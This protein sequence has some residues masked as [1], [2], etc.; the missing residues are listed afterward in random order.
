MALAA[1]GCGGSSTKA[2][3]PVK[4][5][6]F[7]TGWTLGG[8]PVRGGTAIV[9]TPEAPTTFDPFDGT[10]GDSGINTERQVF[11]QLIE[12][13]PN[14][15]GAEIAPALASSWTVSPDRLTYTFKIRKGVHFSNGESLTGEDVVFSLKKVEL[16]LDAEYV[17]TKP[18]KKIALLGPMT[19]QLQLSKPEP[20]L[21]EYLTGFTLSIVPEKVYER[22]GG[23]GFGLHPIGT[24]P[25]VLKSSTAGFSTITMVRN[26]Y[27]WR[28]GKPYLNEL[29]F[30]VVESDNARILAVRSGAATIAQAIPYSQAA[31]LRH[32]PGVKMEIGPEW[33]STYNVFNRAKAPFNEVNVRRALVYATPRE[34][35]IKAVYKGLGTPANSLWGQLKYYD[36]KVPLYP[37]DLQKAK[38]LLKSSSVPHGFD[39][40]I[41]VP[42]G[43]TQGELLASILQSSWAQ[44]GVHATI[45]DIPTTTLLTNFFAG[46]YEFAIFPPEDGWSEV[47]SPDGIAFYFDDATPGFGPP[48]SAKVVAQLQKATVSPNEEER[49]K[50]FEEIQYETYWQEA[51]FMTIANLVSLNLVSDSL[52][53]FQVVSTSN[54]RMD[55][56][57]LQK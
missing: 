1:T 55:Q 40:T 4:T 52:R 17:F 43:E 39:M 36:A 51:D 26:P 8:T 57:W 48:A 25:F 20:A 6:S 50:L 37:Y 30:N 53:G 33:G 13:V 19:V 31:T 9:D 21:L 18:W 24:G 44:I 45:Q 32:T 28:T 56:L 10:P 2:G 16:P 14:G 23:K 27:Y 7:Y 49:R 34:E 35:V 47:Y 38:E 22:E 5:A 54:V 11:D 15:S 29:V 42:S 41:G 3:S 12:M 46:K